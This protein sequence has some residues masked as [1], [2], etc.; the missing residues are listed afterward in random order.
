MSR[1]S[2]D[3]ALQSG[4]GRCTRRNV[5]LGESRRVKRSPRNGPLSGL[6]RSTFT[7]TPAASATADV[8]REN[9]RD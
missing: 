8:E 5:F 9:E 4:F 1:Q 2:D 7:L 3:R 6:H